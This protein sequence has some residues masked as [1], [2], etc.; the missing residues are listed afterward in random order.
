MGKSLKYCKSCFMYAYINTYSELFMGPKVQ[1]KNYQTPSSYCC[2]GKSH[3]HHGN[4]A[5]SS[6]MQFSKM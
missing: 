5:V 4:I 2:H 1:C 6:T 3:W